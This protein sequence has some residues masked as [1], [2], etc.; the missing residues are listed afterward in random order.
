[1]RTPSTPA[2]ASSMRRYRVRF[3]AAKPSGALAAVTRSATP[4]KRVVAVVYF[5]EG[6]RA[7]SSSRPLSAGEALH[8]AKA[9]CLV[10]DL[11]HLK[12]EGL[13]RMSANNARLAHS[14]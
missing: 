14:V 1:M 7:T 13:P 6:S 10:P 8:V 2:Y 5:L 11:G 3:P 12:C 4:T 9:I